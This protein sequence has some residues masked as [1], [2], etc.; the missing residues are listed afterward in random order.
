MLG[1]QKKLYAFV[2]RLIPSKQTSTNVIL[3]KAV[4]RQKPLWWIF[5]LV[6]KRNIVFAAL[7]QLSLLG[8]ALISPFIIK[9]YL[10]FFLV[11]NFAE[12]N[13]KLLL[14]ST[15]IFTYFALFIF[16]F[17]TKQKLLVQWKREIEFKSLDIFARICCLSP[18]DQNK[19]MVNKFSDAEG[20]FFSNSFKDLPHIFFLVFSFPALIFSFILIYS[21]MQKLFI[22][23]LVILA[24]VFAFQIKNQ[25][26]IARA[27]KKISFFIQA[28]SELIQKIFVYGNRVHL[29]A[30]EN[31]F[32]KKLNL[33]QDNSN[34]ITKGVL[35]RFS[36]AGLIHHFS[37]YIIAI[38][39]IVT[40]LIVNQ[41]YSI[42]T[43]ATLVV[44]FTLVDYFYGNIL[45]LISKY[46]EL[47]NHLF[48]AT[49]Y[50]ENKNFSNEIN[51]E[52]TQ[53]ISQLN[54]K[55][56]ELQ[57]KL[58][59]H[60]ASFIDGNT[61]CLYNITFEQKV[62][63]LTA[64]VGQRNSGKSAFL[65]ACT[66]ELKL[67]SGNKKLVSRIE[68]LPQETIL[69][70]SSF[71]ENIILDRE[72]EGRRYIEV[73]RA[74]SLE[75][76]FNSLE[77][78]DETLFNTLEHSYSE[79]F[80]RKIVLARTL[81]AKADFY[82][83]DE[84]FN[85]L[86]S[87]EA[88]L[89]FHEGLQKILAHSSRIIATSKL[90]F[91]S[92]CEE[93]VVMKDGLVAE[94]GTHK[95]LLEKAG[96]YARLHYAAADTRQFG[97]ANVYQKMAE[98][99]NYYRSEI[100]K[101]YYDFSYFDK[102]QEINYLRKL[103]ASNKFFLQSY[104]KN[105]N[106]IVNIFNLV[107]SQ[108]FICAG[109]YVLFSQSFTNLISKNMQISL[110]L[111]FS[112]L[113]LVLFFYYLNKTAVTSLFFGN[114]LE[115]KVYEVLIKESKHNSIY[116]A[117]Y[118]DKFSNVKE[119]LFKSLTAILV[120]TSYLISGIVLLG[121]SNVSSFLA[122]FSLAIFAS[123]FLLI[124]KGSFL[125][126]YFSLQDEKKNLSKLVFSYMRALKV[127]N[128]FH[129]RDFLY[130]K[131]SNKITIILEKAA[132]KDKIIISFIQIIVVSLVLIY[133]M[134]TCYFTFNVAKINISKVVLS[135]LA[136]LFFFKAFI[137]I[138]S[139]LNCYLKSLPDF[140]D[141]LSTAHRSQ[142]LEESTFSTSNYWPEKASIRIMALNVVAAR[143]YPQ[144]ILN[145]DLFIPNGSNFGFIL[146]KGQHK[147]S[148]LFASILQFVP[149]ES[150]T[151]VVDEEDILKLNP[152]DLRSKFAYV[153]MNSIF[154]FLSLRENL[155]PEEIYDDS[156]IW[157]VLN[158]VGVAQSI[159]VLRNGLNTKIEEL[160]KQML[161]S[162]E[163]VFF[164]IAKALLQNNKILLIDNIV[165]TEEAELRLI[166]ILIREFA[167]V[168][169]LISVH[170]KS[171]LLS[172]CSEVGQ[173]E[174]GILRRVHIDKF[175]FNQMLNNQSINDYMNQN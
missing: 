142:K 129:F 69:F 135:L 52:N 32:I 22:I 54:Q 121:L 143:D 65:A 55:N 124:K 23:P 25:I 117:K 53:N 137:N 86:T 74:C 68:V 80:L 87:S 106:A 44:F 75:N 35:K 90:E 78:G 62:G 168:T 77:E 120:R 105:K 156:E 21:I 30:L 60:K 5:F 50:L 149:Y 79:Y 167:E 81:Y 150:G 169:I 131:I 58:S 70:D 34:N 174:K 43:I 159:A 173:F 73:I 61:I 4:N 15:A 48:S 72:F 18:Q 138:S 6:F 115:K 40:F 157:S 112:V 125:R 136:T 161:W 134:S 132:D 153:S 128:S 100:E 108:L 82:V 154:P 127:N 89:L 172:I 126:S 67:I 130:N 66:G 33:L 47:K 38:P 39:S 98:K 160:P 171:K 104:F 83:F 145:L 41:T 71:R 7:L 111:L 37:G 1:Y 95:N 97:L 64:V 91:A 13:K 12:L 118:L 170:A 102:N 152:Y 148:T 113:S 109:F 103:F 85:G 14:S 59:F 158:R 31:F 122:V 24:I 26:F 57:E 163:T 144:P 101:D 9:N 56:I 93:I 140:E 146:E 114:I 96:V 116:T 92:L 88:S 166:E 17:Y 63:A 27:L 20:Q 162:G 46:R 51:I 84:P 8:L 45:I 36:A 42:L 99:V 141:L 10:E 28:R 119:N 11:P 16:I 19:V 155:D 123:L 165:L 164:S 49:V 94:L 151:I 133:L 147:I 76:D 107:F 2:A 175:N 3:Q 139:D 29:L 110:F